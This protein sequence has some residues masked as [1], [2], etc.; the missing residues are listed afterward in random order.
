MVKMMRKAIKGKGEFFGDGFYHIFN[1]SIEKKPIFVDSKDCTRVLVNILLFQGTTVSINP[2]S[3]AVKIIAEPR[4]FSREFERLCDMVNED[5]LVELVTF[6]LMKTHF[7]LIVHELQ[8]DG[9][10]RYM[11]RIGNSFTKYHNTRYER[12]GPL[13]EGSYNARLIDSDDYLLH[14]SVYVHKNIGEIEKW[15]GREWKYPWSSLQDF[16]EENRWGDLLKRET[17]LDHFESLSEYKKYV[18]EI[19]IKEKDNLLNLRGSAV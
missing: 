12:K 10:P 8:Q 2:L 19:K 4:R 1:R 5:R 15:R 16:I 11:S 9:V 13:F 18:Q 7:H 17:I 14:A 6:S 3:R